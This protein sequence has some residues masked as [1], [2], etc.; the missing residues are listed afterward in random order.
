MRVQ[1]IRKL[2]PAF[3]EERALKRQFATN[4]IFI[5]LV[6]EV[7]ARRNVNIEGYFRLHPCGNIAL[8]GDFLTQIQKILRQ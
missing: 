2:L 8:I 3:L 5:K 6:Q 7:A 4:A 1:I